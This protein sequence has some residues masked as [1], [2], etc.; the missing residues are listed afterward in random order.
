MLDKQ[1]FILEYI[2]HRMKKTSVGLYQVFLE[3]FCIILIFEILTILQ[4]DGTFEAEII[5]L[6]D[7]LNIM[8]E[9]VGTTQRDIPE[10][11]EDVEFQI[12]VYILNIDA[13]YQG[14]DDLR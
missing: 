4:G 5:N 6:N 12:F 3:Q 11:I 9:H 14:G 10:T 13:V 7:F 2:L 8:A 1:F